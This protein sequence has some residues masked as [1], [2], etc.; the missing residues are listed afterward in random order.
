MDANGKLIL[1]SSISSLQSRYRANALGG[2]LI[3]AKR[4]RGGMDITCKIPVTK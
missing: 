3:I 1:K 2:E 4:K